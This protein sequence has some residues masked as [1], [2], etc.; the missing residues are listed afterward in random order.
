MSHGHH[1]QMAEGPCCT[2][3]EWGPARFIT[4]LQKWKRVLAYWLFKISYFPCP[5]KPG[6]HCITDLLCSA[7]ISSTSLFTIF[8]SPGSPPLA[9][10][11]EKKLTVLFT[12]SLRLY[13]WHQLRHF[14]TEPIKSDLFLCEDNI[15]GAVGIDSCTEQALDQTIS[16]ILSTPYILHNNSKCH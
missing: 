1:L 4:V 12:I 8:H 2:E 5:S 7:V 13:S 9:L 10:H 15:K 11:Q 3:E 14:S 16:I 6:Y